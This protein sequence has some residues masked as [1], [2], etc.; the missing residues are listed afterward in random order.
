MAAE[1]LDV[2]G[3]PQ[4]GYAAPASAEVK[5]DPLV[6]DTEGVDVE[7]LRK[8]QESELERDS[9]LKAKASEE[10]QKKKERVQKAALELE[11]E[12]KKRK[13]KIDERKKKHKEE[14]EKKKL[15]TKS[16]PSEGNP[17]AR[18]VAHIDLG[19]TGSKD[20]NR[21]KQCILSKLNPTK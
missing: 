11:E 9:T 21:M 6:F 8:R 16:A 19:F 17:W 2:K 12:T 18:V 14:Q 13:E 3:L 15:E 7:L 4:E 10:I 20:I 5:S 1:L